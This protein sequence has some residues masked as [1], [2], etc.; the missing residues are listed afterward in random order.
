MFVS[1]SPTVQKHSRRALY[2]AVRVHHTQ[3][4]T[5]QKNDTPTLKRP[6]L[7]DHST[8][9]E[10]RS[11]E[12]VGHIHHGDIGSWYVWDLTQA[13]AIYKHTGSRRY[14]SEE[15]QSYPTTTSRPRQ[16]TI[17]TSGISASS[18]ARSKSAQSNHTPSPASSA[19]NGHSKSV[20]PVSNTS[21]NNS[22]SKAKG[23]YTCTYMYVYMHVSM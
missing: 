8:E 13:E 5:W 23:T 22:R 4:P 18:S 14:R 21:N 19:T 10:V 17:G 15:P 6:S 11:S 2:Y 3:T 20:S 9:E 16:S 12:R 7:R 1:P